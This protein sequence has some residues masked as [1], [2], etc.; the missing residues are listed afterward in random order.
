MNAPDIRWEQRFS[1]FRRAMAQLDEAVALMEARP[2]SRLEQ[3][4]VIQG[5][6]YSYELGWNTLRDFLVWQGITGIVGSRDTIREAFQAGLVEDG[7]G[8][9]QMLSDRNRTSHAYDPAAAEAIL[10]SI[11]HRHHPL[12]KSLQDVLAGKLEAT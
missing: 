2:L 12:L 11:R 9:M 4:G 10:D 1:N 5:F 3:Q 8:W 6:E 7:K